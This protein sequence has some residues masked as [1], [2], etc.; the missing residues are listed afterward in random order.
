MTQSDRELVREVE[1]GSH[2]GTASDTDGERE[3]EG[4]RSRVMAPVTGPLALM[5]LLLGLDRYTSSAAAAKV[6]PT[7]TAHT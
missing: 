3:R 5:L 4:E 7:F 2:R 1:G 6:S